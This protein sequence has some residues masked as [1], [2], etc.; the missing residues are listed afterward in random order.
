MFSAY[1]IIWFYFNF[2]KTSYFK[3]GYLI[4]KKIDINFL[5][6]FIYIISMLVIEYLLIHQYNKS[7]DILNLFS[8]IFLS[9]KML[10]LIFKIISSDLYNG[11][12]FILVFLASIVYVIFDI[13]NNIIV[14]VFIFSLIR[15]RISKSEGKISQDK[16]IALESKN[17]KFLN[18]AIF[19]CVL[20]NIITFLIKILKISWIPKHI[21]LVLYLVFYL[22][23]IFILDKKEKTTLKI[24]N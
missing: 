9:V 8:V 14:L 15:N 16:I 17:E 23:Y 19:S 13:G 10:I 12:K 6:I 21:N 1:Y 7:N 3:H 2:Y 22:I 11:F 20:T 24:I 18:S 4:E 5:L